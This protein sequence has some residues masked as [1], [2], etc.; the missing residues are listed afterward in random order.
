MPRPELT[1]DEIDLLLNELQYLREGVEE[2]LASTP[3]KD[4]NGLEP[5]KR[6]SLKRFLTDYK[7]LY[8]KLEAAKLGVDFS[9]D[10]ID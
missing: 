10:L 9:R 7:V 6:G 1:H 5:L 4:E 8:A 3:E 2:E